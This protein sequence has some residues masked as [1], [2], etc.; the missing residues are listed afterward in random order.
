MAAL[1]HMT[2]LSVFTIVV[3]TVTGQQ[4]MHDAPDRVRLPLKQ[5]V[6][7]IGHEAVGVEKEWQSLLLS[8]EECKKLLIISRIVEDSLPIITPRDYKSYPLPLCALPL[9]IAGLTSY[10][11]PL[12]SYRFALTGSHLALCS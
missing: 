11:L 1:Q 10:L 6:H 12:T 8:L 4:T 2:D 9:T 5:Q 7:V 3:L